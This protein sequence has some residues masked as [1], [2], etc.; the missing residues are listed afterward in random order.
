MRAALPVALL[1]VA[2]MAGAAGACPVCYDAGNPAVGETYRRS[3]LMLSLLPFGI[4]AGIAGVARW[5]VVRAATHGP[6]TPGSR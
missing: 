6:A 2:A 5:F 1:A 3:T 4:L